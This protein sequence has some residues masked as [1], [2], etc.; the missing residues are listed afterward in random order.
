MHLLRILGL[1]DLCAEISTKKTKTGFPNFHQNLQAK[2]HFTSFFSA[3]KIFATKTP[4]CPTK[5]RGGGSEKKCPPKKS[6]GP[7]LQKKTSVSY[8]RSWIFQARRLSLWWRRDLELLEPSGEKDGRVYMFNLQIY[9]T[10]RLNHPFFAVLKWVFKLFMDV[11]T[12]KSVLPLKLT[13]IH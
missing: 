5:R 12:S 10:S 2:C 3:K 9:I 1:P 4:I 11:G 7:Y 8:R 13:F 6:P